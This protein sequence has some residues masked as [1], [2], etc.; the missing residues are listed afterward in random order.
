MKR[1][2]DTR[3]P[4]PQ[5]DYALALRNAVS[6]LGDRYLLAQPVNRTVS[7]P[8]PYFVETR[9]WHDASRRRH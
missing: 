2:K 8:Q 9:S 7:A 5:H 3:K 1:S 4:L 6:W